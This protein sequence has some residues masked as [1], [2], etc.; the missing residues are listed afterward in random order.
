MSEKCL[1]LGVIWGL[2]WDNGKE[3]EATIEDLGLRVLGF[4][5]CIHMV[6]VLVNNSGIQDHGLCMPARSGLHE[7][8]RSH[9]LFLGGPYNRN[10]TGP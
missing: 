10:I 3:V 9:R 4:R 7:A 8:L 2:Y 1:G 6:S 5:V